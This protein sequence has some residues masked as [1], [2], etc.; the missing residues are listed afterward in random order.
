MLVRDWVPLRRCP[1]F[2]RTLV[3]PVNQ[4]MGSVGFYDTEHRF[5]NLDVSLTLVIN[6]FAFHLVGWCFVKKI[7]DDKDRYRPSM[8]GGE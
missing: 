2:L 8:C 5:S 4:V 6:V 7:R 1:R 3:Y